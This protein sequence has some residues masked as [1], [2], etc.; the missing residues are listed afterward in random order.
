MRRSRATPGP[1][2]VVLVDLPS[3]VTGPGI[4]AERADGVRYAA[5]RIVAFRDGRPIGELTAPLPAAGLTAAQV[6]DLLAAVAAAGS[7]EPGPDEPGSDEPGSDDP[8]PWPLVSVVVAT[9]LARPDALTRCL[10]ALSE[11]DYPR[12]EVIVVDNR[13]EPGEAGIRPEWTQEARVRFVPEPRP[14]ASAARNRGLAEAVGEIV[15]FTDDD[16]AA[17]RRWLRAMVTRFRT[18]SDVDCVTGMVLPGELETP[19]QLWFEASGSAF[20]PYYRRASFGGTPA[21]LFTVVDRLA[22][23]PTRPRPVYRFAGYGTGCN[24]AVRARV[25]RELGGFDPALGPGTPAGAG[26]DLL[27]FLRLLTAGGR[28]AYEP[29]AVVRHWHRRDLAALRRQLRSYGSGF[30]AMLVAAI[31]ADPRHAWGLTRMLT[32]SAWR[33]DDRT[34][35]PVGVALPVRLFWDRRWG[36]LFGP[37]AYLAGRR[38]IR[39]WPS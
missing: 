4:G 15:A 9:N 24:M 26:E 6:S 22:L 7:D 18:E 2:K 3:P 30:T 35:P 27:V 19:A 1:V 5:A 21:S 34:H 23:D 11:L 39:K 17:D 12:F 37:I 28:L 14:G 38:R 10:A 25:L 33:R 31:R 8:G 29:A 16:T 20:R 13:P 36:D 32:R